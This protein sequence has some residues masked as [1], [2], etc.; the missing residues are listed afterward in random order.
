MKING[1]YDRVKVNALNTR[2]REIERYDRFE[3]LKRFCCEIENK[4]QLEENCSE[5]K[6]IL[7]KEKITRMKG[8]LL[9]ER[10]LSARHPLLVRMQRRD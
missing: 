2:R 7:N 4:Q 3:A 10:R 6:G 9:S 1:L 8:S 5:T